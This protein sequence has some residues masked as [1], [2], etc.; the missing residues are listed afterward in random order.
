M[1][2][3]RISV[4]VPVYNAEKY[5]HR[6]IDS[7]LAQTFT[8]FELL[9]IDDGS[10]D[11]SGAICDEYAKKDSRVRVF[12][13][14]NGGVSSARNVGLDNA[15]GEWVA[16][17]D[18]DDYISPD[19]F[20][21]AIIYSSYDLITISF[22]E[23]GAASSKNGCK[24]TII[25]ELHKNAFDILNF[26]PNDKIHTPFLSSCTHLLK[27]DI[28]EKSGIRFNQKLRYGEDTLFIITYLQH[29][30]KIIQLPQV[31][32]YYQIE[33][34]AFGKKYKLSAEETNYHCQMLTEVFN[35]YC[36]IYECQK[37]QLYYSNFVTYVRAFDN[38][39]CSGLDYMKFRN[40]LSNIKISYSKLYY[41][42]KKL[43]ILFFLMKVFPHFF[44]FLLKST[45]KIS[46]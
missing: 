11:R 40:S 19:Y 31:Y 22:Q 26:S 4:I 13:K 43:P 21:D 45:K 9:L 36:T 41:A 8:D 16:F 44:Y 23:V 12:H 42:G 2:S 5:L 29:C 10:K 32:Y 17:I 27:K 39:L 1:E 24:E 18:S 38:F 20:N 7:I 30:A 15:E 28:I 46:K 37:P 25:Y 33:D 6:C 3:P 34:D 35:D 14:K